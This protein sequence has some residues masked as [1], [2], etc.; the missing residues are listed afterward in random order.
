MQLATLAGAVH[1]RVTE[2]RVQLQG[3]VHLALARLLA[4]AGSI[5]DHDQFEA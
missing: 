5:A 1:P 3:K 2:A 4:C